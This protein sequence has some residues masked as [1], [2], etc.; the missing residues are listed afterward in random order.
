M[1]LQNRSCPLDQLQ[2]IT[3]LD[4]IFGAQNMLWIATMSCFDWL[5]V[6]GTNVRGLV[7]LGEGFEGDGKG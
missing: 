1:F 6:L 2:S 4:F 5:M 7:G 3:T